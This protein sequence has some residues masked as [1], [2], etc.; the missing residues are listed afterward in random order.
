[1]WRCGITQELRLPELVSEARGGHPRAIARLISLIEDD[2]PTLREV[3]ALLAPHL[4]GVSVLGLTG[5]P[6]VGKSTTV[7]ELVRLWRAR[8]QR[9]AVLAV[10]PSSPFSG[11]ALLGDR[12][13]MQE[14]ALDPD[15]FM[16]SMSARGQLGGFASATPQAVR[17]LDAAGFDLVLIETVGVGQSE[18]AVA[19]LADTTVVLVAPGMGDGI[20][21]A[22]A[23]ILEIADVLVVNKADREG[24][25]RAV[26]EL[27]QSVRLA[28]RAAGEWE[29]PVL[30][31]AAGR[32]E[33]MDALLQAVERHAHWLDASGQREARRVRRA[34]AEIEQISLA[35]LHT[36]MLQPPAAQTLQQ[37]AAAV[38]A[39]ERDA[40]SAAD[41]L[42]TVL[43]A[44]RER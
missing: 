32:G 2:S 38:V 37:L 28:Q 25:S 8:G 39:G 19:A 43:A 17:V 42:R 36:S 18:V 12:V 44:Q 34:A 27:R 6:G 16:R 3:M 10:D 30:S 7:T 40:Y 31:A 41:R 14:H 15:V 33:G 11:G 9:V 22:K 1:M 4:R 35:A 26:R 5:P 21:A 29:P 24:A 23:G 20:Q 13:R